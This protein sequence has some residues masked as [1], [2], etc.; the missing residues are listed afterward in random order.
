MG[1]GLMAGR[2]RRLRQPSSSSL[3]AA[4]GPGLMAGR[5]SSARKRALSC[6]DFGLCEWRPAG[7]EDG[8]AIYESR[9]EKSAVSCLRAGAGDGRTTWALARSDDHRGGCW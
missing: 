4:M 3:L 7:I 1:P 9:S 2:N 6:G 5:N 8:G